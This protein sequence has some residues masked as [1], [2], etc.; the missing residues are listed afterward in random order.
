MGTDIPSQPLSRRGFLTMTGL[1]G[2]AALAGCSSSGGTEIRFLQNKPE[3]VGYFTGL[4]DAFNASQ[5]E[6]RVTH[7]STPTAL[8]PQ[9][10]RGTPPDLACYNYNLE[11]SNF[12]KR[13]ALTNLADLPQAATIDPSVQSLVSQFATYKSETSCLPYSITAAGMIYNKDLFAQAGLAV[14]TTWPEFIEVCETFKAKG[15]MP[16]EQTFKDTWTIQQGAFDYV[17]GSA[18]DVTAFF[19]ELMALGSDA[20]ADAAVSFTKDFRDAVTRIVAMLDYTNPDAPSR[21]YS[22]GNVAF[23]GGKA[24]MYP[25]GPWAVGEIL[26]VNPQAQIGT[27]AMPGS[28]SAA[29]TKVRVNLDLALWIPHDSAKQDAARKFLQYLMQPAVQDKYNA[30]SL[31]WST[32][33]NAPPVTDPTVAGLQPYLQEARFYQ[34]AGTYLPGAIPVGNYLQELVISRDIDGF[35]RKL[36]DDWARLAR[37]S[38]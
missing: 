36:D 12:L 9:F 24:A 13:G 15:I 3:V 11:T 7:D 19:K 33:K 8:I 23:A 6:V 20:G 21:G 31:A 4:A 35:L 22:D 30:Q 37:R 14:P 2:A 25:Q 27:F 1:A 28:D 10:V 17:T 18:L 26:K 32:T 29:N 38:V 5:D 34:G 16:I